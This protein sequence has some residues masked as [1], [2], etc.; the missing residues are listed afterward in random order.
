MK[1]FLKFILA[2]ILIP[3]IL[4]GGLYVFISIPKKVD[5]T[6]TEQDLNS[7]MEKTHANIKPGSN[8]SEETKPASLEDLL[9]NNFKAIGS[10]PVEGVVTS[11]EVTAVA[12]SVIRGQGLFEDIRI[13]FRDDGTMEASGYIGPEVEKITNLF[14]EVKKYEE[15]IKMAEGKPIYWRYTLSRVDDKK[16]DASTVELRVGQVPLPLPQVRPG[17]KEAGSALNNMVK[18]IDGFS[19][20]QLKIDSEGFH[21]KGTIPEKLEYV[22]PN[23]LLNN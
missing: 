8:G 7:Y 3:V 21:F 1:G 10:I 9:F 11:A 5:V 19:C 15:Y 4:L 17:L 13:G 12:N 6:W 14:P 2:I 22:D 16:F 18:K 23:N 20:E